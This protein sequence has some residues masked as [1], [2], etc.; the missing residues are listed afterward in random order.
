M[1]NRGFVQAIFNYFK[2]S[3]DRLAISEIVNFYYRY[4]LISNDNSHFSLPNDEKINLLPGEFKN[5]I[6]QISRLPLYELV[7]EIV[8]IFNLN[9]LNDQVPYLQAFMDLL[10]E[11]KQTKGSKIS[12]FLEWWEINNNKKLNITAKSD[13]IQLITIHKSKRLEFDHVIIPFLNWTLDN[14]VDHYRLRYREAG[15]SSWEIITNHR[16]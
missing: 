3:K 10:L 14:N 15:A 16:R 2:N 8:R 7:E 13:A 1:V 9:K 12:S 11:Y 4:I 6:F 5:K